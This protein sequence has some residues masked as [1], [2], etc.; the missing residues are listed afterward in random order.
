MKQWSLDVAKLVHFYPL[1]TLQQ[2][3]LSVIDSET[4][5]TTR[6]ESVQF[7]VHLV[8]TH[9]NHTSKKDDSDRVRSKVTA[10]R[11]QAIRRH[12][13]VVFI[14]ELFFLCVLTCLNMS[15]LSQ[16]CCVK[17]ILTEHHKYWGITLTLS[18]R[19][20]R[21]HTIMGQKCIIK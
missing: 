16:N 5:L 13:F 8:S 11:N 14:E 19:L 2:Y 15:T 7:H 18:D 17:S 1:L 4:S 10:E 6:R 3:E 9:F 12:L 20:R 21:N